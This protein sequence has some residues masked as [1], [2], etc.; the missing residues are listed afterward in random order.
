MADPLYQQAFELGRRY[1]T[2]LFMFVPGRLAAALARFRAFTASLE[3][4][5]EIFYSYKTNY[6]PA[7][8]RWLADAEVGAE[9]TSPYEW[10]LA[11]TMQPADTIVVNGLGK[12]ADG[13]LA[14]IVDDTAHAPRLVNLETDTEIGLVS[15]RVP[16]AVPLRVGLR[17]AVPGA[18]E[19]GRDPSERRSLGGDKFGWTVDGASVVQAAQRLRDGSPAVR[20]EALHL[21]FGSQIVTPKR[22]DLVLRRVTGLLKRLREAGITITTL[23]LGGGIASGLVTKRRTGPLFS[24]LKLAGVTIPARNQQTPDLGGFAAVINSHTDE[25]RQLGV[26]RLLFEPGR[27]LAEPAMLAVAQAIATREDGGRRH[28]VLNLGTNSLKCWRSNETRPMSFDLPG[29][30]A[31]ETVELVGPLCHRSDTFGTVTTPGPIHV[32]SLVCFDAVGAY[33]LGDW[34]ANTWRRPAVY[35]QDGSLLWAAQELA[36]LIRPAVTSAEATP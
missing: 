24:L 2:P 6:L 22:Y 8:C 27:Y 23:D 11:A 36:D 26:T 19:F 7:L 20:L 9:V 25:L 5:T 17:I 28:T 14:R 12:C 34:I 29:G 32:G 10:E 13:L 30:A 3:L 35:A 4:E 21:H 16:G 1:P 18:G 33:T 15:R 31:A